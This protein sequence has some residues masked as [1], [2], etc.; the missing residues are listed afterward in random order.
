MILDFDVTDNAVHGCQEGRFFHGY[1]DHYCFPP[2]YVF[3]GGQ[4]LV[5]YLLYKRKLQS[6]KDITISCPTLY[7]IRIVHEKNSIEI[8]DENSA[9]M[10]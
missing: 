7:S 2:L 3:Y 6:V 1:Y 5:N 4:L 8:R 9:M 10:V